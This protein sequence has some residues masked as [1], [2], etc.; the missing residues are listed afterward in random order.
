MCGITGVYHFNNG[1]RTDEK[2]VVAMRDTLVHRGPDDAGLYL[3]P[4]R[5]VGL[6]TRRLKIIDLSD[7]AHMP[8]GSVHQKSNVKNQNGEAW[9]TY[10][11]EVYNFRELRK[12]LECKGYRFR[13]ESDTEV[14]LAS[15]LEYGIDCVKRFNGMFAFVIWDETKKLLFAARD[16]MGIK[17]FF[18]ALQNGTFYFG[19]E[20]KAILAHPDFKKELDEPALSHYLTFSST[21]APFTL[22][23]DVKKL[24]AGNRLVI[25]ERGEGTP[26]EYWNPVKT[27]ESRRTEDS[28]IEEVRTLL[29]DSIRGQ[30][31]SDVPFGCF[32]SGGID[33]STNAKLMSEALGKPVETY[34]VGY[35]DFPA[36]NE[37]RYSRETAQSLGIAPHEILLDESHLHK[38][39][40]QYAY[41]ADDPNGDPAAFPLFWLSKFTRDAGTTVVQIGEGSDEIFAGYDMYLKS[42]AIMKFSRFFSLVFPRW[43]TSALR[44]VGYFKN[45]DST[46]STSSDEYFMRLVTGETPFW[47]LAVAFGDFTKRDILG[48]KFKSKAF[49]GSAELVEHFYR[50]LEKRDYEAD[51]LKQMTYLELKHRLPEFLLA[52]ADKMTMAHSVEGR[53]PFLDKR[54]VELAFNM[55][56]KMKTRGGNAKHILKR[57][58]EGIIPDKIIHRKKQGFGT[59]IA[60]WL[61]ED[62]PLSKEMENAVLGSRLKERELLNY[63]RIKELLA[64]HRNGKIDQSFKI[65]NLITLSLWYDRWF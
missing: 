24:P 9:I 40:D 57:A 35:R 51:L 14:I 58:V 20:I 45:M 60:E 29:R 54:L 53:V 18:Y 39:L 44:R 56:G 22:F 5:K 3:S 15:Y 36:L 23:K 25:N 8:M 47:G 59:P 2:T 32:L 55:P 50:D 26:E 49:T 13:S 28:Y 62:S 61:K 16:H 1:K 10:N 52:R 38:F 34:S 6:G 21:P 41:Y 31:V 12:E 17:P 65:W 30:M 19:S 42:I 48:P 43:I 4:D 7:A 63:D 33:S 64:V 37:F 27:D 46:N 11:G